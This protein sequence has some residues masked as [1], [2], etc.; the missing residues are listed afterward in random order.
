MEKAI[1]LNFDRDILS[2]FKL[3]PS[4]FA[5]LLEKAARDLDKI[6]IYSP[7]GIQQLSLAI[8]KAKIAART[9]LFC[10]DC[11]TTEKTT[12]LIVS[13]NQDTFAQGRAAGE[14]A[15]D[16]LRKGFY[17][18]NKKTFIPSQVKTVSEKP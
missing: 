15:V 18:E 14:L 17:P 2:N 3:I 6:C 4:K 16:F 10:Q 11:Y 1:H 8:L 7:A 12:G 9:V 5:P 13:C